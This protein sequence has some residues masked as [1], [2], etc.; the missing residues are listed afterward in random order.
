MGYKEI[1][2]D[3]LGSG[4]LWAQPET[5]SR[6]EIPGVGVSNGTKPDTSLFPAHSPSVV[7]DI[8]RSRE[9]ESV[10]QMSLQIVLKTAACSATPWIPGTVGLYS[11]PK[12]AQ[13]SSDWPIIL[14]VWKEC[15]DRWPKTTAGSVSDCG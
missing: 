13:L 10:A 6:S 1:L 4:F 2:R 8:H 12:G 11:R 9:Q 7:T 3:I 15:E 5:R 14:P